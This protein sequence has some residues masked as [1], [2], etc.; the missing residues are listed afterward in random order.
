VTGREIKFAADKMLGRLARWLRL[1]GQD[2]LYGSH[3]TGGSLVSAARREGRMIL[4]RDR[5]LAR[6][7]PSE[8]LLIHSDHFREQLKQVVA[9]F[10]IDPLA[11][12]FTRCAECNALLVAVS[13]AEAEGRVPTYVLDT[14]ERF[15]SCP[16]CRR[17]FWRATHYRQ[18]VAE[19]E[20]LND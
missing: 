11:A 4:T 9:A 17:L 14:Q 18:I 15:S 7:D 19:I 8:R 5:A 13:K 10:E 2:V 16:R 20:R 3:L 12:A 1:A 6:K